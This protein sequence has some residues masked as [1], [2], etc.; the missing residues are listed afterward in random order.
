[1][2]KC[3]GVVAG[4]ALLCVMSWAQAPAPG[5]PSRPGLARWGEAPDSAL[6]QAPD[7]TQTS[8][9]D[10]TQA[11]STPAPDSTQNPPSS[12]Q[13][14]P[15][16]PGAGQQQQPNPAPPE[17]T[18]LPTAPAAKPAVAVQFP[19]IEWSGGYSFAQAGFF[20]AGHWAQLNGWYASFGLNA[21][22]WLGLVVEGSEYFGETPIPRGTPLPFPN[23]PPFC[24]QGSGP[25]FNADTREFNILFG[26]QFPY[27]KYLT[28]TPFGE[29]MFGHDGVRGSANG[30]SNVTQNEVSSGLA[31]LAGAGLD[32]KISER[33]A[34]RVK[35]DYLQTRTDYPF[36]GKAKQDNVRFSVGIVIRSVKKK[37]RKLEDEVGVEP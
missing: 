37:K 28:W 27:R 1:V 32:H 24:P 4:V 6:A 33:F 7:A 15:Q 16:A 3:L 17:A 30:V 36:I 22:P 9:P 18:P 20:N 14:S 23:C 35:A 2:R 11:P 25:L 21:A 13:P 8:A 34:L 5:S 31:L 10:S 29:L 12:T 19:R 26:A